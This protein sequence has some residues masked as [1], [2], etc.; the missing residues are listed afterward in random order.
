M[1]V[2]HSV[3]LA[4]CVAMMSIAAPAMP[5]DELRA[6]HTL[7]ADPSSAINLQRPPA[8]RYRTAPVRICVPDATNLTWSVAFV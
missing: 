2:Q 7:A 3:V 6:C 4:A 8:L 1:T 5:L